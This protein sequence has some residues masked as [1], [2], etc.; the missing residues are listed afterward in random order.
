[1]GIVRHIVDTSLPPQFSEESIARL[2]ALDDRP[3][4]YSDIPPLTEEESREIRRM[5]DERRKKTMFSLRL[6]NST[7]LWWKRTIGMGYTSVMAR[8]LEEATKH[9]EWIKE[10][11]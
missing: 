10:C 1:M 9:P 6:Q 2:N 7:I 3:I 4:D 5:A 11:L 8:L